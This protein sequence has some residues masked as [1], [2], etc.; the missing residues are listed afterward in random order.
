MNANLNKKIRRAEFFSGLALSI[1]TG[2]SLVIGLVL[3]RRL[4]LTVKMAAIFSIALMFALGKFRERSAGAVMGSAFSVIAVSYAYDFYSDLSLLFDCKGE[5]LEIFM[6]SAVTGM[7][8]SAFVFAAAIMCAL[9]YM[10]MISITRRRT[11]MIFLY[12]FIA[13]CLLPFVLELSNIV[14]EITLLLSLCFI[15]ENSSTETKLG[16]TGRLSILFFPIAAA[17]SALMMLSSVLIMAAV[18]LP[19]SGEY[20]AAFLVLEKVL[21]GAD[22]I[23]MIIMLLLFPFLLFDKQFNYDT[24][25]T[26]QKAED[27]LK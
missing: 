14:T 23:I 11:L 27:A 21:F 7:I 4:W 12:A 18:P 10:G 16:K 24:Q 26:L 8:R 1:A 15:P 3:T 5:E 9:I 19:E 17:V 20:S 22:P 6:R 2:L 13:A 25:K